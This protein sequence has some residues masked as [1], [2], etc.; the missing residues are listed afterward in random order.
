MTT[1]ATIHNREDDE[2][3]NELNIII[4]CEWIDG[5]LRTLNG[6]HP[7]EPISRQPGTPAATTPASFIR[8]TTD[9][10]H[11]PHRN[12]DTTFKCASQG[13]AEGEG[14]CERSVVFFRSADV[15]HHHQTCSRDC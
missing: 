13:E 10:R 11:R 12:E 15:Y 5:S 7:T 14:D 6:L 4:T 9:G 2:N 3:N 8:P 1:L